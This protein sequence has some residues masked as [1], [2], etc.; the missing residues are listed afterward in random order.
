MALSMGKKHYKIS[1][2]QELVRLQ[3]LYENALAANRQLATVIE[4]M[5]TRES[6]S[7]LVEKLLAGVKSIVNPDLP[8]P[9]GNDLFVEEVPKRVDND[10]AF[11]IPTVS[12]MQS[13]GME[14]ALARE[15]AEDAGL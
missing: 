10:P 6:P 9:E 5:L 12:E 8:A 4:T 14:Q 7:E 15:A 13:W 2:Q 3:G 11:D 1:V